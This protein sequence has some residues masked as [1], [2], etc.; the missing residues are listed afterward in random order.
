MP[1]VIRAGLASNSVRFATFP[2]V[3]LLPRIPNQTKNGG[4]RSQG[5][6]PL[7]CNDANKTGLLYPIGPDK[8]KKR[9]SLEVSL[10]K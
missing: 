3:I 7:Y 8:V 2:P 1:R 4:A 6:L 5:S 10:S 9:L